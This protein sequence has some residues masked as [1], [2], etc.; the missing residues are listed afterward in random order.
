MVLGESEYIRECSLCS[1]EVLVMWIVF[2]DIGI[3][4][5]TAK[6]ICVNMCLIQSCLSIIVSKPFFVWQVKYV[7]NQL[8]VKNGQFCE[9]S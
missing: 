1:W 7:K 4:H 6:Y 9:S 8:P 5:W 2:M 3:L